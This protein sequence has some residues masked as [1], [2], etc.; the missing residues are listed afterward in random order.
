MN[1]LFGLVLI[2]LY[3][4]ITLISIFKVKLPNNMNTYYSSHGQEP[5]CEERVETSIPPVLKQIW[6]VP[7]PLAINDLKI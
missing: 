1:I 6:M 7:F 3:N 2:V 5:M 4:I